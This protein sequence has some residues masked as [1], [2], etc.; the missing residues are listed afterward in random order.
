MSERAPLTHAERFNTG[1]PDLC[2]ALAWKGRFCEKT[3]SDPTIPSTHGYLYWCIY[4]QNC[5]GPDD[6]CA[7]PHACSDTARTCHQAAREQY[8]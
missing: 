2:P 4:T 5:I 1:H 3:E 7:E 6:G 8:S